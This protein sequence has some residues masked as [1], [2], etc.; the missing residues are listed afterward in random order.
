MV[1]GGECVKRGGRGGKV[2]VAGWVGGKKISRRKN[3][4][5]KSQDDVAVV[6]DQQG[7]CKAAMLYRY[8]LDTGR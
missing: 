4:D 5:V 2:V 8:R 7:G 3:D 1:G 6:W